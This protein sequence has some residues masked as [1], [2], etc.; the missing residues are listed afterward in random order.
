MAG[1][2]SVNTCEERDSS[3]GLV[4]STDVVFADLV[5][6]ESAVRDDERGR[7]TRAAGLSLV[8]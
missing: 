2:G 4:N 1:T 8:V 5:L 7:V 3:T 6:I